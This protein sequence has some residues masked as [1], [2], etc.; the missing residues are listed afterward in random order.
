MLDGVDIDYQDSLAL[1]RGL[2]E[3]WLIDFTSKLKTLLPNH[4]IVHT[5]HAAYFIGQHIY[6]N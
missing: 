6:K 3:Q 1:W 4:I 5:A 2:G